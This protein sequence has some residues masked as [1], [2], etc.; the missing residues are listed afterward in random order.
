MKQRDRDGSARFHAALTEARAT[1]ARLEDALRTT[2]RDLGLQRQQLEDAERRG[3]LAAAIPDPE[4]VAIA[5]RF[6]AR[7]RERIELLERKVQIQRD[8]LGLAVRDAAEIAEQARSG[9]ASDEAPAAFA[10]PAPAAD[11]ALLRQRLDRAAREAAAD[12]QLAFLKKKMGKE[13]K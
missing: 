9:G 1:V 2:E 5:E 12:A 6:V 3:R 4:T 7:H 11:E 8:E 10:D 13:S